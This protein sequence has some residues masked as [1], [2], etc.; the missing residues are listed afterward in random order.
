MAGTR[1]RGDPCGQPLSGEPDDLQ[2]SCVRP[3]RWA[4]PTG[5]RPADAP[6]GRTRRRR[7]HRD[8]RR[9]AD[10]RR[11]SRRRSGPLGCVPQAAA[12]RRGRDRPHHHRG[13]RRRHPAGPRRRKRRPALG[14]SRVSPAGPRNLDLRDR[15]RLVVAAGPQIIT[16]ESATGRELWR[17][18]AQGGVAEVGVT[19]EVIYYRGLGGS[20]TVL[21]P[22]TGA[23]FWSWTPPTGS[24]DTTAVHEGWFVLSSRRYLGVRD[25]RTGEERWQATFSDDTRPADWPAGVGTNLTFA[26]NK[27]YFGH[28]WSDPFRLAALDLATGDTAWTLSL[29]TSIPGDV[30]ITAV[31]GTVFVGGQRGLYAV[32]GP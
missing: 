32:A 29:P 19:A 27:C 20:V 28:G 8:R 16:F 14:G 4:D 6:A 24:V 18:T 23:P 30:P 15:L 5:V 1:V 7:L 31:P 13:P 10:D 21:D 3:S 12:R 26:G 11:G 22:A 9:I 2:R 17:H 25:L